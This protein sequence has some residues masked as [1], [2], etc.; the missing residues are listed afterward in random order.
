MPMIS[1]LSLSF[2]I[3]SSSLFLSLLSDPISLISLSILASLFTRRFLNF[4]SILFCAASLSISFGPFFRPSLFFAQIYGNPRQMLDPLVV[5]NIPAFA[6]QP[7]YLDCCL[8][9]QQDFFTSCFTQV[10]SKQLQNKTAIR[11]LL[12]AIS[13]LTYV[14]IYSSPP[15]SSRLSPIPSPHSYAP[16]S[17]TYT[18]IY[19]YS[20]RQALKCPVVTRML[21]RQTTTFGSWTISFDCI[22][23]DPGLTFRTAADSLWIPYFLTQDT[24]ILSRDLATPPN[25]TKY[26]NPSLDAAWLYYMDQYVYWPNKLVFF[27]YI[28]SENLTNPV[29]IFY[30]KFDSNVGGFQV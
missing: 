26:G 5:T 21:R 18:H 7:V 2:A 28:A 11:A 4:C 30:G 24:G 19:I 12:S 27:S 13:V 14:G 8:T 16:H 20:L 3:L 22:K 10:R 6:G 9:A 25:V 29:D 1:F 17:Q 23:L 15:V